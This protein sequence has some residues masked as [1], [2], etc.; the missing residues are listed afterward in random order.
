MKL[1][2]F[3]Q[4]IAAG[5]TGLASVGPAPA[6]TQDAAAPPPASLIDGFYE[7]DKHVMPD[8]AVVRP[9]LWTALYVM[10]RGRLNLFFKNP[11]GTLA[12]ESTI[13]RY[14]FTPTKYCEWITYTTRNNLDAPGA[15]NAAPVLADHCAPVTRKRDQFEFS[16]PGENVRMTIGTAGFRA[17][18][19]GG[20]VD[21]WTKIH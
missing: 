12:S 8:G 17:E 4:V 16:P 3:A 2:K 6:W 18:V 19:G 21:Y 11:D 20:G 14:T 9:P 10:R 13:G 1:R 7:L 5:V 15:T